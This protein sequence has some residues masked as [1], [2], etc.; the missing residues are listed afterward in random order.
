MVARNHGAARP[1]SV[2]Q[3]EE[4]KGKEGKRQRKEKEEVNQSLSSRCV[5]SVLLIIS[6]VL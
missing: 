4:E 2:Q 5:V 3:K 1:R 6:N